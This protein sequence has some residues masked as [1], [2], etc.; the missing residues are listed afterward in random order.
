M[1]DRPHHALR[2]QSTC[3]E[4]QETVQIIGQGHCLSPQAG[5]WIS[6]PRRG[7]SCRYVRVSARPH[8]EAAA[9]PARPARDANCGSSPPSGTLGF[10]GFSTP[11]AGVDAGQLPH[12]PERGAKKVGKR[13]QPPKRQGVPQ[14]QRRGN[15]KAD[16]DHCVN[17]PRP[18]KRSAKAPTSHLKRL[19]T[20]PI[21][22]SRNHSS[23]LSVRGHR[24]MVLE[25]DL[26]TR[27]RSHIVLI[28]AIRNRRSAG[29]DCGLFR[30][31]E[32]RPV[33]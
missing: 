23:G 27:N 21:S 24:N 12:G 1:P 22:H 31:P 26:L 5:V 10:L 25:S 18:E 16:D 2:S 9:W 7:R 3:A 33:P 4:A 17:V 11:A 19:A 6:A 20:A 30:L 29:R 32:H 15:E 13:Q 28:A 8:G 14:Q